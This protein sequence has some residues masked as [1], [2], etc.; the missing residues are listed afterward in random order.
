MAKEKVKGPGPRRG[1][2]GSTEMAAMHALC[3]AAQSR[4]GIKSTPGLALIVQTK[5]ARESCT[6]TTGHHG[7][8]DSG[9]PAH[10]RGLAE[11]TQSFLHGESSF[12]WPC[13]FVSPAETKVEVP[14]TQEGASGIEEK[15]YSPY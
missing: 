7:L 5:T 10:A 14:N 6:T 3:P 4:V 8:S 15:S 2:P 13:V 12:Q 11:P 9:T 1:H